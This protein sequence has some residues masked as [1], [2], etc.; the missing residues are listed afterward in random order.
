MLSKH[1]VL[2][3]LLALCVCVYTH[4]HTHTHKGQAWT[5]AHKSISLEDILLGEITS[6]EDS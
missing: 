5:E 6:N 3:L 4:V 1:K 2:H